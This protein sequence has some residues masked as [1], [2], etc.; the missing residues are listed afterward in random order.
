MANLA[1]KRGLCA[2]ASLGLSVVLHEAILS[3][4]QAQV[5]PAL[6]AP[7]GAPLLAALE[8]AAPGAR[9]HRVGPVVQAVQAHGVSRPAVP[10]RVPVLSPGKKHVDY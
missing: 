8:A 1:S 5:D 9:G 2:Q 4:L 3:S 10:D 6:C 7:E